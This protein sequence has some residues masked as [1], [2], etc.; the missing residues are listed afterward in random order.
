MSKPDFV[1]PKLKCGVYR[2]ESMYGEETWLNFRYVPRA[3]KYRGRFVVFV[4]DPD[5]GDVAMGLYNPKTHEVDRIGTLYP[6]HWEAWLGATL[7]EHRCAS[8]GRKMPEEDLEFML[9]N[10]KT[11]QSRVTTQGIADE[12]EGSSRP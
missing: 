7:W 9:H 6:E 10:T 8:C 3:A 12:D 11:C 2:Y 5:A 4:K 1:L